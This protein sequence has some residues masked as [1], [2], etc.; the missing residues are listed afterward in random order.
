M[1]KIVPKAIKPQVQEGLAIAKEME[2]SRPK[3]V[4]VPDAN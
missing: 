2:I 3:S 1:G 4:Q